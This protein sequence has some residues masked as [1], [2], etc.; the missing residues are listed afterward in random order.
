MDARLIAFLD[1]AESVLARLEPLLPAQRP[2]IDWGTTLAARWQRDG[3]SGYLLPLDVS[4]D[5]RLTDLIGVDKQRDQLGRN[6][7][8]SSTAC[9]PTTRCC[10]AR[11]VLASRRWYV[12]C[13]PS[14]PAPACA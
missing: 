10:G 8:Q 14:T 5:I 9:Q 12:P 7:H 3:R 11:A 13:W 2:H 6:T 4:L 1:R